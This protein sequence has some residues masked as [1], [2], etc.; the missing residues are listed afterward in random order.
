MRIILISEGRVGS[1]SVTDW[2]SEELNLPFVAE[3][4]ENHYQDNFI[5]KRNIDDA[6]I[7]NREYDYYIRLYRENTIKQA[8]SLQRA[9]VSGVYRDINFKKYEINKNFLATYHDDIWAH[10]VHAD[11]MNAKLFE[12]NLGILLSY[13]EIFIDGTGEKKISDYIGFTPRTPLNNNLKKFRKENYRLE[14]ISALLEIKK[15]E[16]IIKDF[17]EQRNNM[18]EDRERLIEIIDLKSEEIKQLHDITKDF[19]EQRKNMDADRERLIEIIE[20]N[21]SKIDNN[22]K[23]LI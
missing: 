15:L 4:E 14:N 6:E 2:L 23:K 3:L 19:E 11:N 12:I 16:N 17:N 13:E 22:K 8:E 9:L 7:Y 18:A 20:L 1:Y 10:K 5:V 21:Q